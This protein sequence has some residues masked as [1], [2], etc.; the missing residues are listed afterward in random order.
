MTPVSRREIAVL[1]L[2]YGGDI[3][4][5]VGMEREKRF[6]Q[7]GTVSVYG[8]SVSVAY[9][10]LYLARRFRITV[11]ER[12][13]VRGALLHDYFLYDWHIPSEQNQWHGFRHAR[14]A[15][16]NAERDFELGAI[17]RDIIRKHMFPL[18]LALP[19]YRESVLVCVADKIC[20]TTETLSLPARALIW[21]PGSG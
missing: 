17:E 21:G 11:D 14:L 8:H 20:A 19:R 9:L 16:Q 5:S 15:L 4:H 12:A 18:N 7:H 3:L 1:L 10:S 13:L 6:M 2:K